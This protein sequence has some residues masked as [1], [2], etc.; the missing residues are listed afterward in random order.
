MYNVIGC[1]LKMLCKIA[2]ALIFFTSLSVVTLQHLVVDEL[3]GASNVFLII[4]GNAVCV[5]VLLWVVKR[6]QYAQAQ[7]VQYI[8]HSIPD[9]FVVKD[10][11][12][13][14][15]FCNA[16]V[17]RLYNTTPQEM[18]GKDDYYF[19]KNKEQADFF[20]QNVQ[21]IL[22]RFEKEE[23]YESSTDTNTGEVRHFHSIKVPFRDLQGEEK[24]LILAKDITDIT[25]LKEEAD[26]NKSRLEQVLEVSEE[27]MWEWNTQTNVVLHNERWEQI[28][29]VKRSDNTF[30]EFEN[31][32]V[33]EDRPKVFESLEKMLQNEGEY[34]IYFR[35]IR[36]DGSVIWIWD[37]GQVAEL[38]SNGK[39]L[40]LVGIVQDVT[41]EKNNQQKI[42]FLAYHDQLTGLINR[43]QLEIELNETIHESALQNVYSAVLFLDLDRFKLLNDSYGHHMGDKLLISVANR[44]RASIKNNEVISRFGGDEFVVVLPLLGEPKSLALQIAQKYANGLVHDLSKVFHLDCEEQGLAIEYAVTASIGGIIFNSDEMSIGEALQLA[45]T[46]LYR[47]KANGGNAAMIYDMD[48]YDE[49][50]HT[51]ELQKAMQTSIKNKDFRIHLQPQYDKNEKI[52]GAEALMR[53]YH[54]EL[55]VLSPGAF[56]DLI[57]ESN[58]I[59]P[60]GNMVLEQACE[61]LQRWQ[62]SS[63][64][65]HLQISINLSAKQIWQNK[66][67]EDFIS[68]VDAYNIAQSKLIVEVTESL[69]IQDVKDATEKLT[70]LKQ[71]GVSISLDDFGTGYSSLNYLR[72]L[73]IDEIKIDRSFIQDVAVDKQALL[74]VK[75]LIEL[76]KNFEIKLIAEG[77][78]TKEQWQLLRDLGISAYQG[79]YF[80]KPLSQQGMQ[81]L[82]REK[83]GLVVMPS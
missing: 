59:V 44:L 23:V 21:A 10:P 79:F 46:A 54:P 74:M 52:T 43:T 34:N 32:I 8:L 4:G 20:L 73:P 13:K 57:E 15:T 19:T 36:P 71:Y 65:E 82:L 2:V 27:G 33:P 39:P 22:S 1:S 47:T 42:E 3:I 75:S 25:R 63:D 6:R 77:V 12:G 69:L 83:K 28:T 56:I 62:A 49:L 68:I 35:M 9:V 70:R 5:S 38:D 48:M 55:G 16:A 11:E 51:S 7:L 66:F 72:A 24:V 37:R 58:L 30:K 50:R 14:F 40:W 26:R 60:I 76:A 45:D 80:S 17:A 78:E 67:V 53:W 41:D 61:Q 18:V 31:C 64:T 29:G 81:E